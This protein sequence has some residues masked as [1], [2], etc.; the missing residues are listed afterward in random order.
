MVPGHPRWCEFLDELSK[1]DRCVRTTEKSEAVLSAMRG[2][3]VEGSIRTLRELGGVCDCAILFGLSD[4]EL[5][6]PA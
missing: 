4:Y 5:I 2:F 6:R 1:A 3:D